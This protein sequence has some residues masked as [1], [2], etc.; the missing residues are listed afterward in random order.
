MKASSLGPLCPPKL[1]LSLGL[2]G[3]DN[4]VLLE[5]EMLNLSSKVG[6]RSPG[7]QLGQSSGVLDAAEDLQIAALTDMR[8][9]ADRMIL[10]RTTS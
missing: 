6:G 4:D 1:G 8:A 3:D 10:W 5:F 7:I 9:E 2:V